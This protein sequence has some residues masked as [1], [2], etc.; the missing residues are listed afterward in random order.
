MSEWSPDEVISKNLSVKRMA[1]ATA[2]FLGT[3][4]DQERYFATL[5]TAW[6]RALYVGRAVSAF[7][8]AAGGGSG[9]YAHL[10]EVLANPDDDEHDDMLEWLGI[11]DPRKFD[12]TD[13]DPKRV[14]FRR[15]RKRK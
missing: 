12:P 14:V 13:F 10:R 6:V 4:W 2:T 9:G 11:D 7:F 3:R 15:A 8:A 5:L 1:A